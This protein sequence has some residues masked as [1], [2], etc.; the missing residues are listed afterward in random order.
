MRKMT[1]FQSEGEIRNLF[2]CNEVINLNGTDYKILRCEKPKRDGGSGEPKTD[3]Y[4]LLLNILNNKKCELKLTIKKA[5]ADFLENK[6]RPERAEIIFGSQ[7]KERIFSYIETIK[8]RF[9]ARKIIYKK[10]EYNGSI[11]L[12]WRFEIVNKINGQLSGQVEFSQAELLEIYSGPHLD[13]SKKNAKIGNDNYPTPLSGVADYIVICTEYHYKSAQ[14]VINSIEPINEY[15][16]NNQTVYFVCKALNYRTFED[17]IE[18]NRSLSVYIDWRNKNGVLTP[19][20]VFDKPLEKSGNEIVAKLKQTLSELLIKTTEDINKE[21]LDPTVKL[22]DSDHNY[23]EKQSTKTEGP[24]DFSIDDLIYN[25][26]KLNIISILCGAGGLDLGVELSGMDCVMGEEVVNKAYKDK[27]TF[28]SIREEG[29]FNHVYSIDFFG[30]ALETYKNNF[31]DKVFTHYQDI[32]K[33]KQFPQGD[34]LLG[35][36][37]SLV[38]RKLGSRLTDDPRN[39]IYIHYIRCLKQVKPKFFIAETVK[40]MLATGKGEA[41]RQIVQ[42]F[43]AEG[44][45]VY[46]KL[47]NA[48]DYGIPQLRERVFLVGVREDI[49]FEYAFP[50]PTHGESLFLKPYVTLKEA[51]GDLEENPGDYFKGP[52]SIMYKIRNRKKHWTEQSFSIHGCGRQTPVHPGGLPMEKIDKDKWIFPDGDHNNRRL[53]VKEIARIQTFPDWYKFSDGDNKKMSKNVRLDRIYKQI[54]NAVPVELARVISQPIA[55]W[56]MENL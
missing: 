45:R 5:N 10:G 56:A 18:G 4:I 27:A 8:E 11:T 28:D 54:G 21:N 51:I 38:F 22:E 12:G 17:E 44:Y 16:K 41:F 14:E 36:I 49:D 43:S 24:G 50:H 6:I 29:L 33:V 13:D 2:K 15:I 3:A 47:V 31:P 39:F 7:W 32:T 42:D 48:R 40:G 52:Y 30:E 37:P 46:H 55:E 23:L 9:L 19:K 53:S 35:G 1:K 25:Q 26:R 20:F 34:I